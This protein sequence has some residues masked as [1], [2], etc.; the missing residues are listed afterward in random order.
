[1]EPP[2]RLARHVDVT[3]VVY[4]LAVLF[5]GF[6]TWHTLQWRISQAL[7]GVIV[8]G[9][10]LTVYCL[11]TIAE[12]AEED[13]RRRL[14]LLTLSLVIGIAT[15]VYIVLNFQEL[16]TVRVGYSTTLDY[17]VAAAF[18]ASIIYLTYDAYGL[19]FAS[20]I[21]AVV[22]YSQFGS[23]FPGW[24]SHAG[25]SFERGLEVGMLGI[26]GVYGDLTQVMG[27]MVA[28]FLLLAGLIRLFGGF[29][30]IIRLSFWVAQYVK[31]GIAQMAVISSMLIG[32][33]NG[34]ALANT[35]I[36]GSFTIPVLKSTG[37]KKQQAAAIE[38]VASTG[39][40][41]MPPVMGVAAFLMADILARPLIDIF[42]AAA[43]PALIF[44]LTIVI[45]V[46]QIDRQND[47]DVS[48]D[49]QNLIDRV[50][51][52]GEWIDTDGQDR[53]IS[54]TV[55]EVAQFVLPLVVLFYYL[56]YVQTTVMRAGM[57]AS[58][59]M[60]LTGCVFAVYDNYYS[61]GASLRASGRDAIEKLAGGM[62]DGLHTL[63]P[64]TIVVAAI[65]L[66]VD[67]LF[68]TGLPATLSFA[69]IDLSGGVLA[70]LLVLTM[71]LCI[72]LGMGMPTSASYL[73]VA[74]LVAPNL[75]QFGIPELSAHFFVLYFAIL[76]AIT[77]PI[78][79][80][81]VIASAIAESNFWKS[82]LEA[83]KISMPVFALP[84]AFVYNPSL[85]TDSPSLNTLWAAIFVV[86]GVFVLSYGLNSTRPFPVLTRINRRVALVGS[87]VFF[88][89][90]GIL[91]IAVPK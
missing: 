87:Q 22:I 77:P 84:F 4:G 91:I 75:I 57:Y 38:S 2:T 33:I 90:V 67:T 41:I 64:L 66:L 14:A 35:S 13:Q 23:L 47:V 1:M 24:L 72:I 58:G 48:V 43:V 62:Y 52:L 83:I 18:I 81:I 60:V 69:L 85:V 31:S 30:L 51:E 46:Y 45:S 40:Q 5:W 82:C 79:P 70:I 28:P 53:S 12:A 17:V 54:Y 6:V 86:I 44:Y 11:E 50:P 37:I 49:R 68:T 89:V 42:V 20:M 19:G 76:A 8:L 78:A 25:L 21:V 26:Q 59:M 27:T 3:A 9:F 56:A 80:A 32:S 63:A 73:V 88:T 65:G 15:T 10:A 74:L 7:F 55:L 71:I 36:T 61:D 39:G 29:G 34:S 16:Q